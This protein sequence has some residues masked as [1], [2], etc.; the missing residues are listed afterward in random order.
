[1]ASRHPASSILLY[2]RT[3]RLKASNHR[4]TI[5]ILPTTS[6]FNAI[7]SY[8][9]LSQL[10]FKTSLVQGH[11]GPR[12][13]RAVRVI[14]VGACTGLS[15]AIASVDLLEKVMIVDL[16][17]KRSLPFPNYFFGVRL[18]TLELNSI[19][20]V[21]IWMPTPKNNPLASRPL[22]SALRR[23]RKGHHPYITDAITK[24]LQEPFSWTASPPQ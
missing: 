2:P 7:S 4:L 10:S 12:K 6:T 22:S 1:M 18:S 8:C 24:L 9:T 11:T 3:S 15:H 20:Q 16:I 5:H 19:S 21:A 23:S 14:V 13:L 17:T